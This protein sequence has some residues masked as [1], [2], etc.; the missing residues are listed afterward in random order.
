MSEYSTTNPTPAKRPPGRPKVKPPTYTQE[1][2]DALQQRI[3]DLE[4]ALKVYEEG[5]VP[6][7]KFVEG[8][9]IL[10][11]VIEDGFTAFGTVW[12]RGQEI[13]L[14]VGDHN[15]VST[16]DKSGSSWLK[17]IFDEK[18]QL[19]KWN[20]VRVRPGVWVGLDYSAN[21]NEKN[22]KI[23]STEADM[24]ASREQR[25]GRTIPRVGI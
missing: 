7:K 9:K 25:R 2:V 11:H 18:A 23:G 10:F 8:E 17:V 14:T 21:I 3:Y 6:E 4:D 5:G 12:Y 24:V 13:E 22:E 16:L 15:W 20:R 1:Q 19:T